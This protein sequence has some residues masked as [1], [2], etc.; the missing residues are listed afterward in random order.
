MTTLLEI[1]GLNTYYGESHILRD[2]DLS[3]K[4]GEMVC[5]IGRNG[6]GKTTLLKSL[7]GLLQP[8]AGDILLEGDPLHRQAPHQRA[9]SGIGYVPQ[10]REIIPQLTV[11]EN[12]MLGMEAMPGGL[13]RHRR[14]D[15]VVYELFPILREFLPRQGG[16]L[17]GGQQQQLAIARAL[18]GKPKLLLLDEPTEGI[19]PNIVQDIEAAVRRIIAETGIGVLLVEQHLH[20]VRQADRYYAMQRGGIVASGP[21]S[22]LSQSVVDQFLSV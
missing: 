7:I 9:R 13:S 4:A 18:L 21:T 2:V 11:E 12:L 19:Q 6:V 1:R 14:I 8:R 22:D 3:V 17:S 16:D 20:F 10:G 15:P 5:L